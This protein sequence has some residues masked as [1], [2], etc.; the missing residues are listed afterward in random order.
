MA[1]NVN[2]LEMTKLDI[3]SYASSLYARVSEARVLKRVII[4]VGDWKAQQNMCHNNA[5]ALHLHDDEYALV[6][7]WL[8]FDLPGLPYVKFV[9]HSAVKTPD[10]EIVDITPKP[11]TATQDYP[12]IEGNLT[13]EDYQ[14]LVEECGYGEINLLVNNA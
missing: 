11:S 12:F 4:D 2:E 13:E 1:L 5:S 6:R 14:H 9:S 10:G 8:Y 3:D 7:G